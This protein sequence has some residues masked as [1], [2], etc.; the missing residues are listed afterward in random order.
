[1]FK[2][3]PRLSLTVGTLL[4]ALSSTA[5]YAA[6]VPPHLYTNKD[7]YVNGVFQ[8]E[9]AKDAVAELM[10]SWGQKMTPEMRKQLWVN[11]FGLGDYQH[12]GL[13]SITWVNNLQYGYYAMTMYLLPDQQIPEHKHMPITEPPA[14][15]AKH[16]SWRVLNGWVYNF[17]EI[18]EA[19]PNPP[20]TASSFGPVK[21]HNVVIQHAG[22]TLSLKK[23]ESY[24]FL[25]ASKKGAIV[26]EYGNWQ[27][28]R[29]WFSSNPKVAPTP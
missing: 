23:L 26:D 7:F 25:M 10:A 24:H 16:E 5:A 19:T 20:A 12:V 21:S 6:A 4:A 29:G 9:V 22:E 28:R 13:A 3:S 18:G 2:I 14:R 15:P 17:S 11:D 1:M 27:D 8:K